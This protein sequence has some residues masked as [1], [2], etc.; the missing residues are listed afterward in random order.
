MHTAHH[1]HFQLVRFLV[2]M[3]KYSY[4]YTLQICQPPEAEFPPVTLYYNYTWYI[5]VVSLQTSYLYL[6]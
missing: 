3:Q 1:N 6:A 5:H 2:I 4:D